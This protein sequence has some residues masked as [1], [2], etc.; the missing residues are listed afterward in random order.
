MLAAYRASPNN[1]EQ[2]G[3]FP[4]RWMDQLTDIG[5]MRTVLSKWPD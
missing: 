2:Y 1:I 4:N 3:P 5:A